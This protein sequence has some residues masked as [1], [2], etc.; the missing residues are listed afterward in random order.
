MRGNRKLKVLNETTLSGGLNLFQQQ[1]RQRSPEQQQSVAADR[2]GVSVVAKE[3]A[4]ALWEMFPSLAHRLA[5]GS[6]SSIPSQSSS[7]SSS[8]LDAAETELEEPT[9]SDAAG[10]EFERALVRLAS[11]QFGDRSSGNEDADND[12]DDDDGA[13]D[14][15]GDDAIA[16]ADNDN[17][18]GSGDDEMDLND[19]VVADVLLLAFNS[20]RVRPADDEPGN[21]DQTGAKGRGASGQV[22]TTSLSQSQSQSQALRRL[23]RNKRLYSFSANFVHL[24]ELDFGQCD[25]HYIKWTSFRGLSSLKRLWLDGNKL[26]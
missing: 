13:R 6:T 17:Y 20:T 26:R 24:Q 22:A 25:L 19:S 7:Q 23:R 12:A 15:S 1:Q 5:A 14:D 9:G 8:P 2:V 4:L 18:N 11:D 21:L 3:T 16:A 10:N